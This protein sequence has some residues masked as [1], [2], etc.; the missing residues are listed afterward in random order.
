MY[1]FG[2]HYVN[3]LYFR[4]IV[5]IIKLN[6]TKNKVLG[7]NMSRQKKEVNL[8]ICPDCRKDVKFN[9]LYCPHCSGELVNLNRRSVEASR[10]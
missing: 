10:R 7:Q 8:M 4:N 6:G 1:L 3:Q 5:S 9:R 2:Y